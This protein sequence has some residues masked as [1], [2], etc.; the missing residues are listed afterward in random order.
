VPRL[1]YDGT[2]RLAL[3]IAAAAAFVGGTAAAQEPLAVVSSVDLDQLAR[4]LPSSRTAWSFL[5]TAEPAAIVDRVGG[6]GLF[7]SE[8][9]RFSMRGA[10]WTQN[11][12]VVDG[13]EV[14]DP[15]AGGVPLLLPD[16]DSLQ[17]IPATSALAPVDQGSPGVTLTLVPREPGSSWHGTLQGCGSSSGLQQAE[18]GPVPTIARLGSLIDL[19]A[20]A[21]G[22]LAGETLG[23]RVSARYARV[24]RFERASAASLE[25]RLASGALRLAWKPGARDA[26]HLSAAAQSLDRP[27]AGAAAYAAP[28]LGEQ[29]TSGGA[30]LSWTRSGGALAA[31]TGLWTGT[32]SP[33]TAGRLADATVDRLL[34][35]P[36]PELVAAPRSQRSVWTAA[37]RLQREAAALGPFRHAPRLG[38]S[39]ER[40]WSVERAG[41]PLEIAE[42]VDGIPARVWDYAWPG[43]DSRRHTLALAAWASENLQLRD[44]LQLE[45]GLRL[46]HTTGAADGATQGVSWT[47]LLPRVSARLRLADAGR[48]ELRGGYAEYGDRLLLQHLAFGDP[49]APLASVY[50]WVDANGDG[51]FDPGERGPLVARVGPGAGADGLTALD[52]ALS[53][54]RTREWVAGL[55]AAPGRGWTLSLTGFDRRESDLIESVDVG[56]PASSYSVRY[57]PDPGGDIASPLDDQLLPVFD[58]MPE[59]FG[60]DRYLL[61]DVPAHRTLYQGAELRAEKPVAKRFFFL[62]GAAAFK[63][64]TDGASRGFRVNENDPGPV[65][66]L[67]DDPNADVYARGRGFFDRA[68]T[69]KIAGAWRAP[70]DL[71]LGVVARY[72]DGQ[73]FA[74]IVVVE[75]LAQGPEP[76]QATARGQQTSPTGATDP[77]GRPLT[78]SGHR[79][80]YAL[81]LDARLEKGL[82]LG[83]TRVALLAEGFNLLGMRNEVEEDPVW[84]P[85]FREPTALQPPRVFRFGARVDF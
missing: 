80:S 18:S 1:A 11:R 29:A 5:E 19:G 74:R 56:V 4:D 60:R 23:V 25:D 36:V 38:V 59:S 10:S 85:S 49:A 67:Y 57:L 52:P 12:F 61:T 70:G 54:P 77:Q 40:A 73:P 64:E 69:V 27:F 51:R 3:G 15:L 14:T 2:V 71:R 84:G 78:A 62:A 8:P 72:Q 44:R 39:L 13:A 17:A 75:G 46:E 55:S 48:L 65:G 28:P 6:V 37:G 34:D 41:S 20:T 16:L 83:A 21:G 79:F 43:A 33:R 31:S 32:F 82:R 53:Q 30:T 50:R 22:P 42:S 47:T 58:R 63:V 81:T 68:F 35:G 9:G 66:E 26:V 24:R 7:P 45:A 76:V